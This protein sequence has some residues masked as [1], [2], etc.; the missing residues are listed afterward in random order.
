MTNDSASFCTTIKIVLSLSAAYFLVL[1]VNGAL[2]FVS[3]PTLGQA[4]WSTGFSQSFANQSFFSVHAHN[5]GA[6]Q[7]AAMAF[8]LAGGWVV[9][10]FLRLGMHAA[11]AYCIMIALWLALALY[12][13]YKFARF[14]GVSPQPSVLA[15][16][17]WSTTAVIW[18]HSDYSML[19]IGIALLPTYY[20]AALNLFELKGIS[21][22]ELRSFRSVIAVALY[23]AICLIS[24][25]MDGYSFM[26]FAVG[27]SIM[28]LI[29]MITGRINALLFGVHCFCLF[30]AYVVFAIYIGKQQFDPDSLDF[31]RG[32]GADISFFFTPTLGV[33][34]IADVIGWSK[35]RSANE[36]FGDSSV[37]ITTFC[38]PLM[39]GALSASLIAKSGHIKIF[40]AIALFG[41]YMSL[42]PSFKFYSTK[43]PLETSV[44]MK[45]SHALGPTGTAFFSDN[46]PGFKSMRASYRWI[47]LAS[48]GAWAI[49]LLAASGYQRKGV[50]F[51]A[52][53]I[54]LTVVILNLPNIPNK[55]ELAK[56]FRSQFMHIDKDWLT[57]M[58][59][60]TKPG[61]KVAF[62]PW[63]NDFLVNYLAARLGIVAYNIGGDKN[64]KE[65]R[66]Q[67][68]I[69]LAASPMGRIEDDFVG[70]V[71]ELLINGDADAIIFPYVD[72]LWAAHKWPHPFK[73]K[74]EVTL[75]VSELREVGYFEIYESDFYSLIR[76]KTEYLSQLDRQ[77]VSEIVSHKYCMPSSCI[78]RS[79]FSL[80][81]PSQVGLIEN[82]R[83]ISTGKAGFLH[84][85]PYQYLDAGNYSLTVYGTSNRSDGAWVD[86]VSQK[87]KIIHGK[88]LISSYVDSVDETLLTVPIYLSEAVQ[89]IEVRVY[90]NEASEVSL[91]AYQF[92]NSSINVSPTKSV[93]RSLGKY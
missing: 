56:S 13:A 80:D 81:T 24:V 17:A 40:V 86:V 50:I 29:W 52:H 74:D 73:Y 87:G 43:P 9:S 41:L 91:G 70:G 6:P 51:G 10:L 75:K 83:L 38:L 45:P 4:I 67:W 93:E 61:E 33:Y 89:D 82:G 79:K 5:F 69:A 88:F 12:G 1:L 22:T 71:I 62:L 7:P 58:R 30:I 54:L 48:F 60:L 39:A 19:A 72:M 26:M 90:V 34:W 27:A 14:M 21:R 65:A 16:L 47:A 78:R 44:T 37:W 20:L 2:P 18:N 84:F 23:V 68:P 55:V 53:G 11:D 77:K 42:G 76:L 59:S 31:F 63:S 57:S 8:G 28:G 35:P 32:W 3:I 25:F 46:L 15:A 66:K 49:I 92:L 64:L 85:G 36:Y